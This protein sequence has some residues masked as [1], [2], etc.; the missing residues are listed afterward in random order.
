ML[1]RL[2][3]TPLASPRIRRC[4]LFNILLDRPEL[5]LSLA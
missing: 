1:K 3:L 2:P 5:V 4:A